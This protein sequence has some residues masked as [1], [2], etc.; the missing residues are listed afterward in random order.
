MKTSPSHFGRPTG[1]SK[2]RDD[3]SAFL[4]DPFSREAPHRLRG[5]GALADV[6]AEE[7]VTS[8]TSGEESAADSRDEPLIEE[9]GGP[10]SISSVQVEFGATVNEATPPEGDREAVPT[11]GRSNGWDRALVQTFN[12]NTQ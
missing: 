12:R 9:V 10:F 7:F 2:R 6:L 11:T 8:A 4:P 5:R 3:G 1:R